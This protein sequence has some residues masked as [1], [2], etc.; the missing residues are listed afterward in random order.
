MV[1]DFGGKGLRINE[2]VPVKQPACA[3]HTVN[4]SVT[5]VV[6]TDV[7]QGSLNSGGGCPVNSIA[8]VVIRLSVR[9][10]WPLEVL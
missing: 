1:N 8:A 6:G 7:W 4:D 3:R 10:V 9:Q 5:I 2:A